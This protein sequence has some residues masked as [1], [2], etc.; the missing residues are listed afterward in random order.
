MVEWPFGERDFGAIYDSLIA[1]CALPSER[2]KIY[3]ELWADVVRRLTTP[4]AA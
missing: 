2:S 1:T 3:L 4:V